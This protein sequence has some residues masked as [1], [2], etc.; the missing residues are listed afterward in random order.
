MTTSLF[1]RSLKMTLWGSNPAL[2]W[3]KRVANRRVVHR[4]NMTLD[5]AAAYEQ[6]NMLQLEK[7]GWKENRSLL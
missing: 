4:L 5:A 7:W 6:V 2:P 1:R 3:S